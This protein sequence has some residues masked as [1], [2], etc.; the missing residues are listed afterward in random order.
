MRRLNL[1]TD[2]LKRGKK[3]AFYRFNKDTVQGE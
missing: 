1:E 3:R 2:Y